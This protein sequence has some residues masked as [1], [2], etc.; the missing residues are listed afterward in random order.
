MSTSFPKPVRALRDPGD[1]LAGC[2]L[3]AASIVLLFYLIPNFIAEPPILQNPMMS[4]RWLPR[5]VGWLML[6]FSCLLIVQG[7]LVD[8]TNKED[9]R[10]IERGP[11]LRFAMMVVALVVYVGLVRGAGC[12]DQRHSVYPDS[13]CRTSGQDLVGLWP[14]VRISRR[15]HLPV[16][17]DHERTAAADA[18]LMTGARSHPR[19]R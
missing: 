18:I 17:E 8:N 4:P 2:M 6:G 10:R 15:C 11:R 5:I 19:L 12:C 13:V 1:V 14:G 16:R 3:L 7:L 9:G